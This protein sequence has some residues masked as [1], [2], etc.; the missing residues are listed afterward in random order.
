M[1]L[2]TRFNIETWKSHEG[3]VFLPGTVDVRESDQR[4]VSVIGDKSKT[5]LRH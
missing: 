2:S 1:N 4:G 5:I 3:I